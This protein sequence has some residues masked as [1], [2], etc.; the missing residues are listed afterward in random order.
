MSAPR[1]A[2][3]DYFPA[4][5]VVEPGTVGLV[6]TRFDTSLGSVVVRHGATRRSTRATVFLHGAAGSWTTWTPLLAT[7]RHL[8]APPTEPVV[9][10]LPGWGDSVLEATDDAATLEAMCAVVREVSEALGYPEWDLVG[11]SMGGL[12]ALHMATL[13]PDRVRSVRLVSAT[14]FSVI[15]SVAHPLRRFTLLPGFTMMLGLMRVLRLLGPAGAALVSVAARLRLLR[16]LMLPLFGNGRRVRASIVDA[17]AVETRPRSFVLAARVT[18]GY[19]A[20]AE[21]S[22]IRCPIFA[23]RGS[24]DVFVRHDDFDRLLS[25]Q[26][27]AVTTVLP[28]TGHFAH[29]ERPELALRALGLLDDR[30]RLG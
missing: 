18:R 23:V 28:G 3:T 30:D 20:D 13:W 26:P 14:T 8:G 22:G 2:D 15:D 10:D 25:V 29:I 6:T 1:T 11:H 21:W 9:F 12:I 5:L 27:A 4:E 7:A 17:L 19:D 16:V 24:D